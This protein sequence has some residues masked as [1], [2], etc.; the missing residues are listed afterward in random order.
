[1]KKHPDNAYHLEH[2]DTIP[3]DYE[4]DSKMFMLRKTL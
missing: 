4:K 1:M 3:Q 2:H